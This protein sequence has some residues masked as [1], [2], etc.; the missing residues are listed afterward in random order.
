MYLT[1]RGE[2]ITVAIYNS[3]VVNNS[4]HHGPNLM[5]LWLLSHQINIIGGYM[6]Y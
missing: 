5:R 3:I 2:S 4:K 6:Y 1:L